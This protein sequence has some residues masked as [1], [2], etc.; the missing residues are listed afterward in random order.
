[1]AK[2]PKLQIPMYAVQQLADKN[3]RERFEKIIA[4]TSKELLGEIRLG[5]DVTLATVAEVLD[6]IK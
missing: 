4:S 6:G 5:T 3:K 1:M 2:E